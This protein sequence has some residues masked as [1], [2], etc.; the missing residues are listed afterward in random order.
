MKSSVVRLG[1]VTAGLAVLLVVCRANA[2]PMVRCL[3]RYPDG[4]QCEGQEGWLGQAPCTN[5]N[6]P[7]RSGGPPPPPPP[8]RP[9]SRPGG[10]DLVASTANPDR[11]LIVVGDAFTRWETRFG[12]PKT[13]EQVLDAARRANPAI[14]RKDVRMSIGPS[15]EIEFFVEGEPVTHL[16]WSELEKI[17]GEKLPRVPVV[18]G[19]YEAPNAAFGRLQIEQNGKRA[20]IAT[21]LKGDRHAA[22]QGEYR[23]ITLEDG[24]NV[25]GFWGD[26]VITNRDGSSESMKMLIRTVLG[27]KPG[28]EVREW[29]ER[30]DGSIRPGRSTNSASRDEAGKII[31]GPRF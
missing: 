6:C 23:E 5:P 7:G 2:A 11:N 9:P 10:G 13:L 21:G 30:P 3:A 25:M 27:E 19:I 16:V 28:I 14:G 17:R 20:T 12:G 24:S 15:N 18:A 1:Q 26:I 8:P 4:R 29:Y 31:S 22:F